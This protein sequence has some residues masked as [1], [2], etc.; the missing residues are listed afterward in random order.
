M[1]LENKLNR[2]Y[3]SKGEHQIAN[4][5]GQLK[6]PFQYEPDIYLKEGNR[7][8][9]WHPDFYLP[10]YHTVIEYLGVTGNQTYNEMAERKQRVY[11]ANNYNFIGLRPTDMAKDY[12]THIVKAID[13]HLY[14]NFRRYR[15]TTSNYRRK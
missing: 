9:I 1:T 14:G 8:Y 11:T 15:Q 10:Q 2:P 5:L 13:N 4:L 12:Q 6:I 7:R 3:R